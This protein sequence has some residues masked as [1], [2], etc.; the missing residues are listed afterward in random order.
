MEL[1]DMGSL[2]EWTLILIGI[3]LI[4]NLVNYNRINDLESF[5]NDQSKLIEEIN[6]NDRQNKI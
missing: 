4:L 2:L 1:A 6:K 5:I 3:S